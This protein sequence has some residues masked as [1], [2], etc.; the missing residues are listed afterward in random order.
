MGRVNSFL[1]KALK[2]YRSSLKNSTFINS[3]HDQLIFLE[4]NQTE[5]DDSVL[6]SA[7]QM[8][9][10]HKELHAHLEV[11]DFFGAP[12]GREKNF[13]IPT[14]TKGNIVLTKE[15]KAWLYECTQ[16][17]QL[18]FE[19]ID[20]ELFLLKKK[21]K[22]LHV[23]LR[24]Q[25]ENKHCSPHS[26]REMTKNILQKHI[27]SSD[28]VA[29]LDVLNVLSYIDDLLDE[30][31]MDPRN[32]TIEGTHVSVLYQS[33][34][35][36]F[37][38]KILIDSIKDVRNISGFCLTGLNKTFPERPEALAAVAMSPQLTELLLAKPEEGNYFFS[39]FGLIYFVENL[40]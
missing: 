23:L 31:G 39:V 26:V 18:S 4:Q 1:T 7:E 28:V 8:Q 24:Q 9:R 12:V 13:G 21:E 14:G 27:G 3:I 22:I 33:R 25:T 16:L 11:D 6:P 10:E 37:L 35:C 19:Q 15:E 29:S 20:M 34:E 40:V 36:Y 38:L 2:I 30:A 32:F 5:G 17:E